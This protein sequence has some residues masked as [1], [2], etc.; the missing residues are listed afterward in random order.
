LLKIFLSK[1][2]CGEKGPAIFIDRDGVINRRRPDDYV[3]DF[4]QFVFMPGIRPALKQLYALG[5][6]MIVIS[7][8][9]AVGKGL[10][11]PPSLEV[12]TAKMDESL[13]EDGTALTAAYFCL[14]RSDEDCACRKPKPEMF[15]QAAK[16]FRID[17]NRSVF[18]G[19]SETDVLAARAAGCA[20]V[21]FGKGLRNHSKSEDW[22]VDLPVVLRPEDLFHVVAN[23]LQERGGVSSDRFVRESG[24]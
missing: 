15:Y 16:D 11:D 3:L 24:T 5:L 12:I 2:G 23:L 13:R 22:A 18:I 8:Q 1:E 20:P 10:L 21:I 7:N 4:S 6:P 19:D 14:H 9:A 17:L